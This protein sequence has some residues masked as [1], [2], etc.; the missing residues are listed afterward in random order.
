MTVLGLSNLFTAVLSLGVLAALPLT[1]GAS[2]A[3]ASSRATSPTP[4]ARRF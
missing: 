4:A 3:G 1:V 2:P